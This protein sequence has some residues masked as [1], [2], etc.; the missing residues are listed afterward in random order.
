MIDVH[1]LKM[2]NDNPVWFEQCLASLKDEPVCI[3]LCPGKVDD[4]GNAR[5]DAFLL[6]D[7][8]YVSFVDPDDYVLPGG[9]QACVDQIEKDQSVA[10]YTQE[11][12]TGLR[13]EISRYPWVADWIHHLIVFKR[14]TVIDSLDQWRTWNFSTRISE[15]RHFVHY[16]KSLGLAVSQIPK[17]Y[18]VWRKHINSYTARKRTYGMD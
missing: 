8:P 18:Y 5:A 11:I 15:G 2:P 9:F 3:H 1:L 17:P 13:G 10:A 4:I 7:R 6:G 14:S 16:L 12:I